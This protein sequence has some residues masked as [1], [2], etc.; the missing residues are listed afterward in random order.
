[1][2]ID[3]F[4]HSSGGRRGGYEPSR[5]IDAALRHARHR[6]R[7]H[8]VPAGLAALTLSAPLLAVVLLTAGLPHEVSLLT[9]AGWSLAQLLLVLGLA[10]RLPGT[11]A[12]EQQ[13]ATDD[14]RAVD[15][16][17]EAIEMEVHRAKDRLHEV[18]ATVAGIG[19]THRLLSDQGV[20]VTG[21]DRTRLESLYDR[22]IMRLERLLRDDEP[23]AEDDVDVESVIDPI[24]ESLRVRGH[25]V[26][27][28]GTDA[29]AVGRDDDI[30]EIL[31]ILLENAARHAPGA[32][33]SVQV[34]SNGEQLLLTVSDDGPG[35]PSAL[36]PQV[37]DRGFRGP[38]S[39]GE[40]IGLHI[41]RR[42]ARDIGGDLFLDTSAEGSGACFTVVLRA[43]PQSVRCLAR[44]S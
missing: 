10:R 34:E 27:W 6:Q 14:A 39:P 13:Q 30:A 20:R 44:L 41:A 35:V 26:T 32:D 42:L 24:V 7:L 37:F 3:S 36:A 4:G 40:G 18:R 25:R 19:L 38:E 15:A 11:S 12:T 9:M 2:G 23:S 31:H 17:D 21:A 8:P 43:S 1:M 22:E 5:A 29:T 16:D 33:A 28:A